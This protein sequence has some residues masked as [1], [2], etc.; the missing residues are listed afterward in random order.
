MGENREL[1]RDEVICQA[2]FSLFKKKNILLFFFFHL[3]FRRF[4]I[5]SPLM[6]QNTPNQNN[7]IVISSY[8]SGIAVGI[9][10]DRDFLDRSFNLFFNYGAVSKN[11]ELHMESENFGY[12]LSSEEK[13]KNS[14]ALEWQTKSI[15]LGTS[16]QWKGDPKGFDLAASRHAE[17]VFD[18][19]KRENFMNFNL[20]ETYHIEAFSGG[21]GYKQK[22]EE[23]FHF[24]Q[25]AA[26]AISEK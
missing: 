10:G 22:M 20:G 14:L 2:F 24:D 18:S 25:V 17:T 23:D 7:H 3:T 8:G 26:K 15:R 19:Y 21:S 13:L 9:G 6:K 11:G 16:K 1:Y 12:F 5:N 4:L